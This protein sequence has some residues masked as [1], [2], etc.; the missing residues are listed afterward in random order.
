MEREIVMFCFR[1]RT[2]S[3]KGDMRAI[4]ALN[5]GRIKP[6]AL[7]KSVYIIDYTSFSRNK[8]KDIYRVVGLDYKNKLNQ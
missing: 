8:D 4:Y 3:W 7:L 1:K 6:I 5:K 2:D